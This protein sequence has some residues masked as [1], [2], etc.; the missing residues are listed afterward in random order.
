MITRNRHAVPRT[1]GSGRRLVS[2]VVMFTVIAGSITACTPDANR[3]R[4]EADMRVTFPNAWALSER[5]QGQGDVEATIDDLECHSKIS[6]DT[7]TG[8][9]AWSCLVT[10][11]IGS[12][13]P[14]TIELGA[15]VDTFGCYSAFDAD[16]RDRTIVD[17]STGATVPDPKAG[18]DGCFD[19]R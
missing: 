11:R 16:H 14:D 4:L 7:D 8:P 2:A 19:L 1:S 5:L 15:S 10:Y 12:T 17:R 3:A 6:P 9:G 13:T 18:F